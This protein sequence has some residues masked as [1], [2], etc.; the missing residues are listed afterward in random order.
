MKRRSLALFLCMMMLLGTAAYAAPTEGETTGESAP[1]G[2]TWQGDSTLTVNLSKKQNPD[3][4]ELP[5][6]ETWDEDDHLGVVYDLY[7]VVKAEPWPGYDAYTY[8]ESGLMPDFAGLTV[9][10]MDTVTPDQWQA[11]AK[12][13]AAKV[14]TPG[15]AG[16]ANRGTPTRA[17]QPVRIM[18]STDISEETTP[19]STGLGPGLYLVI[20]HGDGMDP[21]EYIVADE[22]DS[23][24]VVTIA[25]SADCEYTFQP[26][27]VSLPGQNMV[28]EG[29]DKVFDSTW[30]H[31]VTA[32]LKPERELR[33]GQVTLRKTIDRYLLG[34]PATFVFKVTAE[35]N[36]KT[37]YEDVVG[38]TFQPGSVTEAVT[39]EGIPLG[40]TVTATEV[41]SG[42]FYEGAVTEDSE[43]VTLE[44][45]ELTLDNKRDNDE[46]RGH[47][48]VNQFVYGDTGWRW[49]MDGQVQTSGGAGGEG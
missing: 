8:S 43:E 13:A 40:A 1:A 30:D 32:A 45:P 44:V 41:Y 37:V 42:A 39:L 3:M 28:G 18:D 10:E 47:G 12:E 7:L 9:P 48:I 16:T 14:L 23:G 29:E 2:P 33:F 11:M 31:S 24:H 36:G 6:P 21:S 4:A 34:E 49:S 17:D 19:T 35:K 15:E 38:L 27:L 26:E 25:R 46:K 22:D 20:A 5:D